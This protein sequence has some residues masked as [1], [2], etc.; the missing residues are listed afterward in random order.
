VQNGLA[1]GRAPNEFDPVYATE[2]EIND[3]NC[4]LRET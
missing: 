4:L 1:A 3:T 2:L